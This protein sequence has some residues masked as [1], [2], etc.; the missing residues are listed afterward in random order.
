[1]TRTATEPYLR[2]RIDLLVYIEL[3]I[4]DAAGIDN[5]NSARVDVAFNSRV[6]PGSARLDAGAER[7]AAHSH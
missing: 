1:V 7:W 5:I 6:I 4:I 2:H 3:H